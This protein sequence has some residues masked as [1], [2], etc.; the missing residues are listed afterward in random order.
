MGQA[1]IDT[2]LCNGCSLC[3]QICKFGA[4]RVC[5][6][7]ELEQKKGQLE[8]VAGGATEEGAT[9]ESADSSNIPSGGDGK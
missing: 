1:V 6:R 8:G 9:E 3:V 7:D 2:S 4:I 5:K